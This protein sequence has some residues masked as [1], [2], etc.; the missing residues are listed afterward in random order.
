MAES[1]DNHN[2]EIKTLEDDKDKVLLAWVSHPAK[3][4]RLVTVS[5]VIFLHILMALVYSLTSSILFTGIAGVILF[6]SLTQYFMPTKFRFTEEKVRIQYTLTKIEKEWSQYR[7]YYRD[8]NGV[9]LS[10]FLRRQY[11]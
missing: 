1:V 10:P 4:R 5:V 7:S 9:L 6:G 3:A 11:R 2:E 8:K